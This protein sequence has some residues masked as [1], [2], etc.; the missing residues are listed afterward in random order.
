[1]QLV[2]VTWR[3]HAPLLFFQNSD[4]VTCSV[5]FGLS[6]LSPAWMLFISCRADAAT[7]DFNCD[8]VITFFTSLIGCHRFLS[9]ELFSSINLAISTS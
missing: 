1:M 7:V 3:R 6:G 2:T 8:D 9:Q 4:A 5:S